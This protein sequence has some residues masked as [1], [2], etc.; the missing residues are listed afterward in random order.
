MLS[1]GDYRNAFRLQVPEKEL[2]Q[3]FFD[4]IKNLFLRNDFSKIYSINE[5]G[6]PRSTASSIL[7]YLI[8][9]PRIIPKFILDNKEFAKN[10][11]R[12][13]FE[14]EGSVLSKGIVQL[15]RSTELPNDLKFK[16]EIGERIFIG[17]I[18]RDYPSLYFKLVSY[19]PMT[20]VGEYLMLKHHF[21][22]QSKI[23]PESVRINK[24]TARRGKYSAKWKLL[25][26]S[27]NKNRFV[28]EIGF[29]SR[30]KT[31][32]AVKVLGIPTRNK[33]FFAFGVMKE[34]SRKGIFTRENLV[35]KLK[36]TYKYPQSFIQNYERIGIIKRVGKGKYK[37]VNSYR[38][39]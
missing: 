22:I 37:I 28:K 36:D 23:I 38:Q 30:V 1:E 32:K 5:N 8:P 4:S 24:T 33:K 2:H 26:T 17:S 6:I 10:Y 7:R 16:G 19:L 20:L 12:I 39:E 27:T 3:I 25:I 15:S 35:K 14:S 18:R 31:D 13:A 34:I 9:I 11:L 21:G 29:V